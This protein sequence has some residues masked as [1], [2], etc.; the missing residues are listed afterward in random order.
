MPINNNLFGVYKSLRVDG[1]VVVASSASRNRS[2]TTTSKNFIQGT[3]KARI[4]DIGGTKEQITI[5]API[6][7]GGGSAVDGRNLANNRLDS[8]LNPTTATLPILSRA[9][10]TVNQ[11]GGNVSIT[12]ESDGDPATNTVFEVR[13]SEVTELDPIA[14]TPTRQARFYDFRVT[15][16]TRSYYIMEASVTV[17]AN[18]EE[19][20]FLIPGGTSIDGS[21]NLTPATSNV[22]GVTWKLGK[23]F[24]F[25]GINGIKISG[26][27]KAAVVLVD[28]NSDGDFVDVAD[29]TTNIDLTSGSTDITFQKPGLVV[30]ADANFQL[31]IADPANSDWIPLLPDTIDLTRSVVTTENFRVE[32]GLLTVDFDFYCWVS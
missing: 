6:L 25:L 22:G 20:Y 18:T 27:G 12:L 30:S 19:A 14:N 2:M 23:Q 5:D 11:S 4:L 9:V 7:L 32:T 29:S 21:G 16:G 13:S 15:I 3:P 28:G 17:E 1:N 31:E 10:Y 24:P 26:K 8:L